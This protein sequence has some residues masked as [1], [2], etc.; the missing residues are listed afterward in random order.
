MVGPASPP[1]LGQNVAVQ[2]TGVQDKSPCRT[3]HGQSMPRRAAVQRQGPRIAA[4]RAFCTL[5]GASVPSVHLCQRQRP[6]LHSA[7]LSA[8]CPNYFNRLRKRPTAARTAHRPDLCQDRRRDARRGHT[9]QLGRPARRGPSKAL[10]RRFLAVFVPVTSRHR[11]GLSRLGHRQT[12][13]IPTLPWLAGIGEPRRSGMA[14]AFLG[15]LY[16][17]SKF[18]Q[19]SRGYCFD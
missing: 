8:P 13:V 6:L 12:P 14:S 9:E 3:R 7:P 16:E 11:P 19:C 4:G 1:Q 15:R 5:W 17:K 18:Y 2:P 10:K